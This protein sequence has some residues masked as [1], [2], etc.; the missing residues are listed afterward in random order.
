MVFLEEVLGRIAETGETY[1]TETHRHYETR[2]QHELRGGAVFV[3]L[4]T[5]WGLVN[6]IAQKGQYEESFE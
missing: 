6:I 1:R 5:R 2:H 4:E 3:Q